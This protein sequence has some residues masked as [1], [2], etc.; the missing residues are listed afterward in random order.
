MNDIA[1]MEAYLEKHIDKVTAGTHRVT[2]EHAGKMINDV[3]YCSHH[4]ETL[5]S[6][7]QRFSLDEKHGAT[8]LWLFNREVYPDIR[9]PMKRRK[10]AS[11][12]RKSIVYVPRGPG[13]VYRSKHY[14]AA[15]K[16]D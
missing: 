3:Q 13:Q 14:L 11:F 9:L 4:N 15:E 5:Q 8:I 6:I 12:L 16:L 2:G 7:A 1:V 10:L